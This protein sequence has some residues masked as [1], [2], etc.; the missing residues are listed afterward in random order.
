MLTYNAEKLAT[1]RQQVGNILSSES[2]VGIR[3]QYVLKAYVWPI[4][5]I[6]QMNIRLERKLSEHDDMVQFPVSM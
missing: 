4:L 1:F 5:K 3:Q 2:S 6:N